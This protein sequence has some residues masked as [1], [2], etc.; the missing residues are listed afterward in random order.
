MYT[1]YDRAS[2]GDSS[3]DPIFEELDR[4]RATVFVHLTN[5][6]K[7]PAYIRCPSRSSN[8]PSIRLRQLETSYSRKPENG[9]PNIKLVFSHWGG[10]L[11]FLA[12]RL[13]I[14][15][16]LSFQGGRNFNETLD[17]L[18]GYYYD[19]AVVFRNPQFPHLER[20]SGFGQIADRV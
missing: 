19:T 11:P 12:D 5:P 6:S 8:I 1:N 4:R 3:F 18:K 10:T 17:E 16:T 7:S 20:I 13:A 2:L 14:Q 15:T 9:S